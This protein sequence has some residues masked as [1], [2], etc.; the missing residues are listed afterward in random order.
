MTYTA[1]SHQG[2]VEMFWLHYGELSCRLSLYTLDV[3]NP[4]HYTLRKTFS[5]TYSQTLPTTYNLLLTLETQDR[6]SLKVHYAIFSRA[7]KQTK[8]Q[9]SRCKK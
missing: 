1:A 8:T 7:C 3:S 6:V 5:S 9:S 2:T 4:R